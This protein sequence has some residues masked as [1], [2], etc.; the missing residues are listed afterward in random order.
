M[1]FCFSDDDENP[2][3]ICMGIFRMQLWKVHT[4]PD[5]PGIWYRDNYAA[6]TP[7]REMSIRAQGASLFSWT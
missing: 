5:F 7:A 2:D 6:I 1:Y 3:S 4:L